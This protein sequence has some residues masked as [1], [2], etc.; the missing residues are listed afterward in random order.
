M[1]ETFIRVLDAVRYDYGKSLA[2]TSGYRCPDYNDRI[3]S[4]GRLG[5]HTTGRA[6]DL[7]VVGHD[8]YLLLSIALDAGF[9]GIG[10]SQKG[11]HTGR[12]LHLDMLD[13]AEGRPRPWVWSY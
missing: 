1:S 4:T 5:P 7:H 6:A 8:A 10:V 2:V 9:T 13:E 11:A 12:F 3:S